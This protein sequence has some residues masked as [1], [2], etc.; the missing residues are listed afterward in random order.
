ME[1]IELLRARIGLYRRYLS[2]GADGDL[3]RTYLWLI[4]RDEME[5]LTLAESAEKGSVL[6]ANRENSA[7]LRTSQG[8]R[9]GST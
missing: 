3:A 6:D 1:R 9:S 4:R 8:D 5:L 7:R 2:E